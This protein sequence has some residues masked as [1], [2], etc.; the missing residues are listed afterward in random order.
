[1]GLGPRLDLPYKI[2]SA[3]YRCF[4]VRS[5]RGFLA[6]VFFRVIMLEAYHTLQLGVSAVFPYTFFP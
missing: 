5:L 6:L 1:M 4:W 2:L 3:R